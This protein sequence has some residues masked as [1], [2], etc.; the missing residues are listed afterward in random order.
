MRLVTMLAVA[1]VLALLG[2]AQTTA[3][4]ISL[5]CVADAW[6][7]KGNGDTNYGGLTA[8]GYDML[9]NWGDGGVNAKKTWVKFDLSSVVGPVTGVT[10]QATRKGGPT[11][12][13]DAIAFRALNDGDAGEGWDESTLTYNNAPANLLT[14]NNF[15]NARSTILN[16]QFDYNAAGNIGDV[17]SSVGNAT[18]VNAVNNDT[19]DSFTLMFRKANN[20]PTNNALFAGRED[21]NYA[22]VTLILTGPNLPEPSTLLLLG[23]GLAG[24][25][26]YAW[27]KRK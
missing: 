24:L 27:R 20:E 6:G 9:V 8:Y 15:D 25:S 11:P 5:E 22:G 21:P 26:A 10:V 14:A 7:M 2:I 23:T 18:L 16:L 4:T 13:Y 1:F 19:N 3:G 17:M 12:G